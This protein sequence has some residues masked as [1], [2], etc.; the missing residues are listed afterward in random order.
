M[1]MT[2]WPAPASHKSRLKHCC[3]KELLIIIDPTSSLFLTPRVRHTNWSKGTNRKHKRNYHAQHERRMKK[4]KGRPG[5]DSEHKE[6]PGDSLLQSESPTEPGTLQR[7]AEALQNEIGSGQAV[8][9]TRRQRDHKIVDHAGGEKHE[10][11]RGG[12]TNLFVQ[13]TENQI[14][15]ESA[16]TEVPALAPEFA[17]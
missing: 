8:S 1:R 12:H 11:A 4:P 14:V 16:E 10:Q 9:A 7:D 15:G 13:R 3:R 5:G 2:K 6:P 17:E